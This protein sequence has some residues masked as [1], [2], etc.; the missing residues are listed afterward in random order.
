METSVPT[1]L[2]S[3]STTITIGTWNVKTICK[4]GKVAQV[5]AEMR[6][7]NIAV[8]VLSETNWL[9][10]GQLRLAKGKLLLYS[11]HKDENQHTLKA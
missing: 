2:M 6:G 5:S 4:S 8:L 10:A 11:E 3:I 1:T 9:Q 7:Y